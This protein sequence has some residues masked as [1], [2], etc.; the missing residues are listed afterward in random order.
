MKHA[1]KV[2]MAFKYTPAAA[3]NIVKTFERERKKLKDAA[4]AQA[5]ADAEAAQ[6]I[7]VIKKAAR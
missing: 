5:A 3:T 4:D 1:N 7:S 6:K 2:N